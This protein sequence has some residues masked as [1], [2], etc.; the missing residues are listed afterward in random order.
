MQA[1]LEQLLAQ[2][3]SE[4]AHRPA[5]FHALLDADVWVLGYSHDRQLTADSALDLTHWE[6]ADGSTVI[7][8]FTSEHALTSVSEPEAPWIKLPAR[9]LFELTRGES[10]F[11]NPKL[12]TGKE[13]SA[14]E[15]AALLDNQGNALTEHQ[16][17]AGGESLLISAVSEPPA[18]L[19]TSLTTLFSG[20]KAVRRAFLAEIREAADATANYLVGIEADGEIEPLI[21]LAGNVAVDTLP[22]DALID[23][24]AVEP[25]GGGVSHFLTAHITPFYERRWGSFLR[26]FK[27]SERII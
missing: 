3:A 16:V 25:N 10:L 5:F 9:T 6:K 15:I 4:P 22:D 13:F 14:V 21:Q 17:M 2:A 7:P 18:Q 23:L 12:E 20:Q 8:F 11:L 24:C 26:D 19:I 1:D 27:G